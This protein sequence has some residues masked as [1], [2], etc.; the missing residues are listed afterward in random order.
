MANLK[1]GTAVLYVAGSRDKIPH[2]QDKEYAFKS[3]PP[4]VH[5]A[6]EILKSDHLDVPSKAKKAVAAWLDRVT[7]FDP[8]AEAAKLVKA[9]ESG[10]KTERRAAVEN[11]KLLGLAG[12]GALIGALQS[13][14][15]S[16]RETA[17]GLL[18][19]IPSADA[20]DALIVSL[21]DQ[22]SE[23]RWSVVTAL[24]EIGDPRALSSIEALRNDPDDDVR[25]AVADAI[26]TLQK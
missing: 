25:D 1:P 3:V 4:L 18:G 22:D 9:L 24:E 13:P 19:G 2:T 21:H 16:V 7:S 14:T 10:D 17:A 20:T 12:T 11:L 23:V 26:A 8:Q 5:N 15:A 6:F